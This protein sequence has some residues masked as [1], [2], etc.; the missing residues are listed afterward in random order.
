MHYEYKGNAMKMWKQLTKEQS[1]ILM[2]LMMA[3]SQIPEE[4]IADDF[5]CNVIKKRITACKLPIEYETN[6]L[7]Y[8]SVLC[9]GNPGRAVLTLIE[10][11]NRK[12]PK[13]TIH[14]LVDAY[15]DGH[16]TTEA[17]EKRIDEVRERKSEWDYL[18]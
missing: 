14:A 4:K 3:E 16:Y 15:P 6:G 17:L 12:E 7:V 1:E 2:G 9:E 11:L 13:I 8:L 18:Y 5:L 10:L